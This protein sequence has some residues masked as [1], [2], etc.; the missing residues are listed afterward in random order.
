MKRG[1]PQGSVLGPKLYL[2]YVND[3]IGCFPSCKFYLY[4]DD[5]TIVSVHK[6]QEDADRNLQKDFNAFLLWAHDKEL[7]I[8]INKTEILHIMLIMLIGK[9][10]SK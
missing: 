1:V 4:A 10:K 6:K 8:N 2:C 7:T 5:S 9:D 3:I